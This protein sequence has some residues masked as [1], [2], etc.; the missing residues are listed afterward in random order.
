MRR[1][2]PNGFVE[3]FQRTAL[4]EFFRIAFRTK[5]YESV[6]SVQ[7]DLDAWLSP[8]NTERPRQGYRN[9]GRRPIDTI[10]QYPT[11]VNGEA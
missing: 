2:Q 10:N 6:E 3:R 7:A 9:T 4:D 5:F 1:P 8:Y 11:T